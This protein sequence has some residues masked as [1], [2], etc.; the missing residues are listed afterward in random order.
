MICH[1]KPYNGSILEQQQ[2]AAKMVA[3]VVGNVVG[4]IVAD[5]V[6]NIVADVV[7]IVVFNTG[8]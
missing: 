7:G 3:D 8:H 4:N 6:G 5:V 2:A 1:I